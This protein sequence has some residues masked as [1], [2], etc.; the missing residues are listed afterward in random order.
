MNILKTRHF[1]EFKV[2]LTLLGQWPSQSPLQRYCVRFIVLL[3]IF[4]IL[5]PKIIKFFEVIRDIDQVIE[6]LPMIILHFVTLTKYFNWIFNQE[7]VDNLILHID[8]DGKALK[9]DRDVAIMEKW[10]QR[11]RNVSLSYSTAMFSILILYLASPGA[12]KLMD[13]INPLNESRKRI[14]LYQTE[15]FVD[16]EEYYV[17]I[18]I[19]AYMTV[20][21]S[22]AVLVYFDNLVGTKVHHACAMFDIL[23]TYLENINAGKISDAGSKEDYSRIHRNIVRCVNM[24]KNALK[25][26]Q[27]LE[28]SISSAWLLVLFF[29][30]TII[31]I[32]G[33]VT[34]TKF[35]QPNEAFKFMAFTIGAVFHL[36][37]TS[38]QGQELIDQSERVFRAAYDSKWYNLP[39]SHQKLLS[40]LIMKSVTPSVITAG[41]MYILS[42]D[43]FSIVLKNAMSFFTVLTS[44]R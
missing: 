6:C 39:C 11:I 8:R 36:F 42:L 30:L 41:G 19:H 4:S 7:K 33:T 12:P 43:T 2:V 1:R 16:Q 38:F 35:D 22:V 24:H 37:Y 44:M 27:D 32:T 25:F 26:S 18:L 20:P 29:S 40:F 3:A 10:L 5:T 13:L 21:I 15:Y 34:T 31:S 23:S 28:D 17:H 9:L 14:F